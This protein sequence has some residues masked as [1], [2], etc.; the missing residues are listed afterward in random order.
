MIVWGWEFLLPHWWDAIFGVVVF[1]A[2]VVT[3]GI[4]AG[5]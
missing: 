4:T 1:T 3:A 2:L 5:E